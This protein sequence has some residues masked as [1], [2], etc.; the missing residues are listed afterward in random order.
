MGGLI[1]GNFLVIIVT[2][3]IHMLS[4]PVWVDMEPLTA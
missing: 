2:A 3:E 1:Q 4:D